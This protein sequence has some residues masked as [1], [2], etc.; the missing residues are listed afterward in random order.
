M[1][2]SIPWNTRRRPIQLLYPCDYGQKIRLC[3]GVEVRFTDVGHLLGSAAVEVWITEDGVHEE[4]GILRRRGES[5]PAYHQGSLA[6]T[7]RRIIS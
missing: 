5:G 2:L 1:S 6:G 3:E 4:D 7:G